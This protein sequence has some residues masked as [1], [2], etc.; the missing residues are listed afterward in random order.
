M[1]RDPDIEHI[2]IFDDGGTIRQASTPVLVGRT[3]DGDRLSRHLVQAD[4]AVVGRYENGRLIQSVVKKIRNRGEC[5]ACHGAASALGTLQLD[6]SF[7]RTQNDLATM[8][9]I[10]LW[11]VVVT[12]L[13]LA[14][15]GGFLLTRMVDRPVT[16]LAHAMARV[17]SGDL[18]VPAI[19]GGPDELGRLAGSFNTMVDRLRA[20]RD[21]IGRASCRERVWI[22]V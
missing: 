22:P 10:A 16:R 6:M 12:G 8:E 7:R 5:R 3:V 21:E 15:G 2:V 4:F 11:T 19:P 1:A 13:V 18:A 14:T 9:R 17:E 20:A